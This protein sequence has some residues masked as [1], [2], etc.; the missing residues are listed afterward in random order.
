MGCAPT[1]KP[2][3]QAVGP[4]AGQPPPI[5]APA[6]VDQ[7][8]TSPAVAE[9]AQPTP[10]GA[11]AGRLE[12]LC[13]PELAQCARFLE[14]EELA[15]QGELETLDRLLPAAGGPD[16]ELDTTVEAQSVHLWLRAR[17]LLESGSLSY[18]DGGPEASRALERLRVGLETCQ[19][20]PRSFAQMPG[21]C[22][23]LELDVARAL[24]A[25]GRG[26]AALGSLQRLAQRY[27]AEPE[28]QAALGI[29]YLSVGRVL[30]SLGP[31]RR[32]AQLDDGQAERHLVL[33]TAQMLNGHYAEAEGSFRAALA[34]HASARAHGDLGAVLLLLGRLEEGR[35]H[36][37]RAAALAP[38][39]ATY[40]ANLAYA[41]LL[42]KRPEQCERQA[43][44]ALALEPKLAAAWLNL[45]LCL[46]ELGQRDAARDTFHR[47][48]TL[49]PTDP[50]PKNSLKDLDELERSSPPE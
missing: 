11:G 47:A 4:Q 34:R 1:L 2:G 36:L 7:A 29:A 23:R 3:A 6:Q 10:H 18:G 33:G 17:L 44:A 37:E 24:L 45:G 40:L 50:R 20:H 31:L 27:S 19:A 26:E 25:L 8:S 12:A 13:V 42:L 41:E 39:Q 28:V 9:P 49:D 16:A 30:D 35:S 48:L 5:S 15:E 43:R 21:L 46:V 22:P 14:L 32:A 38:S